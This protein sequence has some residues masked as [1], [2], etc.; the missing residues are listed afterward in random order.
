MGVCDE[1][2]TILEDGVTITMAVPAVNPA[3]FGCVNAPYEITQDLL[4]MGTC[5]TENIRTHERRKLYMRCLVQQKDLRT[6]RL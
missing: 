2:G 6:C 4:I 3:W 5:G 1:I